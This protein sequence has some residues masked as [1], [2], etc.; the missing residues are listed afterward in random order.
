MGLNYGPFYRPL[1]QLWVLIKARAVNYP[2]W[3]HSLQ[4]GRGGAQAEKWALMEGSQG[5]CL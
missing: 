3:L 2:A 4:Q 1:L 5:F